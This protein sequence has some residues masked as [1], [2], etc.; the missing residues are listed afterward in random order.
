MSEHTPAHRSALSI[1]ERGCHYVSLWAVSLQEK[2]S[3]S[4]KIVVQ[5][6]SASLL[7][8]DK[9]LTLLIP[10]L[11]RLELMN[12]SMV[13]TGKSST[14]EEVINRYGGEAGVIRHCYDLLPGLKSGNWRSALTRCDLQPFR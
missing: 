5:H 4:E 1:A 2:L 13:P 8:Q 10:Q 14:Y 7:C 12:V 11:D 9:N 3:V 6:I